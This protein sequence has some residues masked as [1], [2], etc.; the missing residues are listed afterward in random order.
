MELTFVCETKVETQKF[1]LSCRGNIETID[2]TICALVLFF[3]VIGLAIRLYLDKVRQSNQRLLTIK[4]E[5]FEL[6]EISPEHRQFTG[7][8]Y[9]EYVIKGTYVVSTN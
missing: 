7:C 2:I 8:L 1:H 4:Y 9:K 3:I 5:N 6:F